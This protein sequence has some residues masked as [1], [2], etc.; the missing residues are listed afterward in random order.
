MLR[1]TSLIYPIVGTAL[2]GMGVTAVLVAGASSAR[3]I[4]VVAAIGAVVGLPFSYGI[5]RKLIAL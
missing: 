3:E 1:L 4:I 5:A 2:A